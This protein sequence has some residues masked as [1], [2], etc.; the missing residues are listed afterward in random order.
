MITRWET[1]DQGN[2]VG[3]WG[4]WPPVEDT[5]RRHVHLT[6]EAYGTWK[7]TTKVPTNIYR[8]F[9]Y[10]RQENSIGKGVHTFSVWYRAWLSGTVAWL[11]GTDCLALPFVLLFVYVSNYDVTMQG[12]TFPATS[13]G[14]RDVKENIIGIFLFKMHISMW[15]EKNYQVQVLNP[16]R[17]IS[18][19]GDTM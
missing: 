12:A 2:N 4:T 14:C 1:D 16:D 9:S 7:Q 18:V 10:L 19:S 5:S 11:S 6:F 17:Q 13:E 15:Y 3:S 8:H